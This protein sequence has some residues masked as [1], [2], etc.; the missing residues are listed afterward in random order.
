MIAEETVIV[1]V[2]VTCA[3]YGVIN[4][5]QVPGKLRGKVL[6]LYCHFRAVAV[7]AQQQQQ[8]Q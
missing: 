3:F 6:K 4:C 1:M 7:K 5:P 8:Q 2:V